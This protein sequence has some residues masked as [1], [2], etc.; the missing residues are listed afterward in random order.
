MKMVDFMDFS[1]DSKQTVQFLEQVK[2]YMEQHGVGAS[3][4]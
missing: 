4:Y 1:I 3:P 2:C